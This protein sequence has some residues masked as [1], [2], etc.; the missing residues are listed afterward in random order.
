MQTSATLAAAFLI[1]LP[2]CFDKYLSR[3]STPYLKLILSFSQLF[4]YIHVSYLSQ[5]AVLG[6]KGY[7]NEHSDML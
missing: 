3:N 2:S 7:F 1:F 4:E 5:Y 6:L